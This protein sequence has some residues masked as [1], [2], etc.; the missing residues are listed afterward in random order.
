MTSADQVAGQ[1][2]G[3]L[4]F[5]GSDDYLNVPY[6]ADYETNDR[7]LSAWVY[8]TDTGGEYR[9]IIGKTREGPKAEWIALFRSSDAT[10]VW[11]AR[12]GN[13]TSEGSVATTGVWTYLVMTNS[14]SGAVTVYKNG[15]T[16]DSSLTN[17][18]GQ[19]VAATYDVAIGRVKSVSEFFQG[20]IDPGGEGLVV[21]LVV[22]VVRHV[23][24]VVGAVEVQRVSDLARHEVGAVHAAVVR[25][26]V[27]APA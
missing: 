5:D 12:S 13:N 16:V 21:R 3:S 8:S 15:S 19:P 27:P 10:G 23:H 22:R 4:D 24:V 25:P 14:R 9:G 20:R 6:H 26:V 18:A 17:S 11:H 2:G 7:T 1:I